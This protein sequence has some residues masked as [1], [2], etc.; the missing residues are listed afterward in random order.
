MHL[1]VPTKISPVGAVRPS[2]LRILATNSVA[3]YFVAMNIVAGAA[4]WVRLVTFSGHESRRGAFFKCVAQQFW[5]WTEYCEGF[6]RSL[7]QLRVAG[8]GRPSPLG[9]MRDH[10]FASAPERTAI[11]D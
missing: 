4:I 5:I 10:L 7:R 9:R 8:P 11:S 6:G 1:N 2:I 3:S